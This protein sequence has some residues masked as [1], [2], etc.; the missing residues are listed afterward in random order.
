MK[1]ALVSNQVDMLS[2]ITFLKCPSM[3]ISRVTHLSA[4]PLL[5]FLNLYGNQLTEIDVS[6]NTALTD[7][8][9]RGNPFS[10]ETIDHLKTIDWIDRLSYLQAR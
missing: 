6:Q 8:K 1:S 5:T 7:L 9:L 4:F 3:S 10:Q 2:E